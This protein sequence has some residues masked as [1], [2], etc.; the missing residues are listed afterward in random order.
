MFESSKCISA[1]ASIQRVPIFRKVFSAKK[2]ESATLRVGSFGIHEV[3]LNG[4]K[5]GDRILAPGWQDYANRICAFEYEL[6]DLREENELTVLLMSGWFSGSLAYDN[7]EPKNAFVAELRFNGGEVIATDEHWQVSG[8]KYELSDIYNGVIY[9]AGYTEVWQNPE[10][11][12]YDTSI[13]VPD[14]TVPMRETQTVYPVSVINAPNG[15]KILDFGANIV[16]YPILNLSAEKGEKVRFSFAEILTVDGNFYNENYR[17]AKCLYEYIC[18]DGEQSFTPRGTYYGWRYLRID[19][20]PNGADPL[21]TVRAKFVCADMKRT[22]YIRTGN[23]LINRLFDNVIRGQLGNYLA[24]PTDCP[25]RDERLGWSGDAQ[26]F[27]KAAAYNFDIRAFMKNWFIDVVSSQTVK[28]T[29]HMYVPVPPR[30]LH[31]RINLPPRAAW[32]DMIT[33]IPWELFMTYGDVEI[34]RDCFDAMKKHI[35]AIGV[36]STQQYLYTGQEQFGDWLGLDSPEG[37]YLGASD[38]D[39][40]SSAY[41]AY[42]TELTVKIGKVL[43]E[44]VGVYEELYGKIRETYIKTYEEKLNTQTE[45]VVTLHF[46]LTDNKEALT[47]RLVEKIHSE[48]DIMETGFVGTPYILHALSD[49]GETELAYKLLVRTEFPSWLYPVTMGATTIWE[50]WDGLRPDGRLWSPDMNSYNHYAYG[51]VVDWIYSVAAGIRPASAGYERAVIAPMPNKAL[52]TL[53]VV[54]E[55]CKGRFESS[56]Y[57]EGDMPHYRIATPVSATVIINGKEFDVEAGEYV[58]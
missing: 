27:A 28:G 20:F 7:D 34:L 50:H 47:K 41:Y 42:S 14:T 23:E 51:A 57:Y 53:D 10:L 12:E 36:A 44:D 25:Q 22:G 30:K 18:E 26:I 37:S 4:K 8:S 2:G 6:E 58:F 13:F 9:D 35:A 33:I 31:R 55:S 1:P 24:V 29:I 39:I 40:I 3:F 21:A 48:G 32:S 54:F 11:C 17:K 16:G 19:E 43:G 56:W 5:V 46:G 45:L 15:D 49:N 52:G 38:C